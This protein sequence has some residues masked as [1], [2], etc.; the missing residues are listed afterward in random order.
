MV[1]STPAT[2]LL[3]KNILE[4]FGNFIRK[5]GQYYRRPEPNILEQIEEISRNELMHK[6]VPCDY[7]TVT[8]WKDK[9]EKGS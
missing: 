1:K 6:I 2:D 7:N 5:Y 3:K 4:E 9:V 8:A